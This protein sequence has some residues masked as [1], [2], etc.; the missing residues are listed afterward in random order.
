[1]NPTFL[2]QTILAMPVAA[3]ALAVS[4]ACAAPIV[5]PTDASFY[6]NPAAV[7]GLHGDLIQY[8][9]TAANLGA[10]APAT[11][12]WNV[13]YQ[14]TDSR[15][16][17]NAVSGT[18]L[19]PTAVWSGTG[20]RPVILYAVGTH[21]LAQG[22]APSRQFE[23]GSDYENANINAALKAGYAVLVSDYAGYLIGTKSTYMSG[24]SQG[25]ATLDIFKAALSIPS[26]GISSAAKVGIWGY[27][28]GGQ[29]AA[30]AAE[31]LSAYAP[32]INVAG[33]AAGG[34]PADFIQTAH[35]LD[36]NLGASFLASAVS[37]L[38][39]QYPKGIPINLIASN[40]G[41]A[42]LAKLNTECVFTA[43]FDL[44]NKSLS[45]FTIG[46]Q[47]LDDLL[48]LETVNAT[49]LAQGLGK[50]KVTVPLYQYH[51][52][53]DEFIELNQ[54]LAL[55]KYYCSVGTN[56]AFDVYP[57]EHIV[58]QFQAAPNVLSWLGDRFAGKAAQS[59]CA[60]TAAEPTTTANKGGGNFVVSLKS[61]PLTASVGLKTLKQTVY[62]PATSTFS[63]ETD[64]TGKT[65]NGK[66]SVPDFKQSLKIIGLG[67]QIGMKVTPVGATTGTASLD[68][69][70]QLHVHGTAY[71]DI[72]I[73]SVS[74]VPV[75]TCKTV[76]PVAFPLNF[77]G[78]ISSLGNG[79]LVFTGTTTF[80]QIKGC[81]ISAILTS[82][83]SG[84]GQ[85]Y[86]F[87]VAPPAP[88]KY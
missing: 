32:E 37:G 35:Y 70:G 43:L 87:M 1:M 30:W 21:G 63:A 18:V 76:T 34:I 55:R 7:T 12:A 14:S 33:V 73:T 80:P 17:A 38:A 11:H 64:I 31:Q 5:G 6:T 59:T 57:S 66:L 61:W 24:Q 22:C 36:A 79:G 20:P 54:D 65:L 88:V 75:G 53:A 67:S 26:V 52:Q 39:T 13:L 27:S 83:M 86:S 45:S 16:A 85:T 49:L 77:D 19:V 71:A 29:S 28:Q 23:K 50:Q 78:P 47:P 10:G 9:T 72:T 56:V 8:R 40:E 82:M 81:I 58:T 44:Q 4:S 25:N 46:D 41:K 2:R 51:G 74:G 68:N 69:D 42:E 62:L 60:N 3:L 84:A 15:G 48:G